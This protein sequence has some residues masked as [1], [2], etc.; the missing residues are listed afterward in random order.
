VTLREGGVGG[1]HI[2]GSRPGGGGGTR[3]GGCGSV[4]QS[5]NAEKH[6]AGRDERKGGETCERRVKR[7]ATVIV[8][9]SAE[10][11]DVHL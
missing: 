1:S 9:G 2:G 6:R 3:Q 11:R 5:V 10:K 4:R 7:L 8:G